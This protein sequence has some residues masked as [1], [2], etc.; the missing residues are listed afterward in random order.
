MLNVSLLVC[1]LFFVF[2]FYLIPALPVGN[3]HSLRDINI[4]EE[5]SSHICEL[6][7][8]RIMEIV[9]IHRTTV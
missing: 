6:H 4:T 3:T 8:S 9:H 1:C 7:L 2:V 5:I